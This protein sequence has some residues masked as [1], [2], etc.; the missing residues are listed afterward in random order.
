MCFWLLT[1]KLTLLQ[2]GEIVENAVYNPHGHGFVCLTCD[3]FQNVK[4]LSWSEGYEI[5]IIKHYGHAFLS[6]SRITSKGDTNMMN[7]QPIRS[8]NGVLC[9]NGTCEADNVLNVIRGVQNSKFKGISDTYAM[10]KILDNT[11]TEN[12][13]K[14]LEYFN[15]SDFIGNLAYIRGDT[16]YIHTQKS[17]YDKNTKTLTT[18]GKKAYKGIFDLNTFSFDIEEIQ[19]K[20][21]YS[22]YTTYWGGWQTSNFAVSQDVKSSES[23]NKCKT[24]GQECLTP[25]NL[26]SW[27]GCNSYVC[28]CLY[29]R[30]FD[31]SDSDKSNSCSTAS[32]TSLN[33]I[34]D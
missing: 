14:K 19:V 8:Q 26:C 27:C 23:S 4:T 10:S 9:H 12:I 20:E 3:P 16:V 31:S 24:S 5:A 2:M 21:R 22:P 1:E 11:P 7:T 29:S 17:H 34:F 15:K 28:Y 13:F 25:N 33:S 6:H 30:N 32:Q 18:G